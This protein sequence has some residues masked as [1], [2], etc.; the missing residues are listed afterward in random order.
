MLNN[1]I[2]RKCSSPVK[3]IVRNELKNSVEKS[4]S[5]D[6]LSEIDWLKYLEHFI[7]VSSEVKNYRDKLTNNLTEY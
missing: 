1:Q 4:I 3:E 6:D 7:N 5:S 2:Q